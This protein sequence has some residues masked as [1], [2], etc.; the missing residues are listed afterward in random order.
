MHYF[1][2]FIQKYVIK[3]K[4]IG[5]I[6]HYLHDLYIFAKLILKCQLFK[7]Y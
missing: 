6:I 2:V 7:N 1:K 4:V 3:P 5:K